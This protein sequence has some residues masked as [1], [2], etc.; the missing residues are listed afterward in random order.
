[1]LERESC[2]SWALRLPG[3][4]HQMPRVGCKSWLFPYRI[5]ASFNE[6]CA[7]IVPFFRS[8]IR[9]QLETVSHGFS[10][11][12]WG[13]H[14]WRG[15]RS[16]QRDYRL[17]WSSPQSSRHTVLLPLETQFWSV[18]VQMLGSYTAHTH[19]Q[20]SVA[21]RVKSTFQQQ[22]GLAFD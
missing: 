12:F 11:L 17:L 8:D 13:S 18:I 9:K 19:T 22:S 4:L 21:C 3:G 7:C 2:C 5:L 15:C 16:Q 14:G 10:N 1:M 20:V 6:T